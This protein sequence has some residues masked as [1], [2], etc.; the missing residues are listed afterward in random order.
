MSDDHVQLIPPE[1][2]RQFPDAAMRSFQATAQPEVVLGTDERQQALDTALFP[3]GAIAQLLI[4]NA[5]GSQQGATGTFITLRTVLTAGHA[6]FTGGAY[7]QRIQV[8]PGRNG[9]VLPFN[10]ADAVSA[11]AA[12]AWRSAQSADDDWGVAVLA[13][14][15]TPQAIQFAVLSDAELQNRPV[16]ISGYPL[17]KPLGTQWFDTK[18]IDRPLQ[19]RLEYSADTNIGQ[20]G[21]PILATI[22]GVRKIVGIHTFGDLAANSG[23]RLTSALEQAIRAISVA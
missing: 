14:P 10:W 5:D 22:G 20:S 11:F 3:C 4:T 13:Q 15:I 7:A 16:T 21:A 6:V 17:D 1:F 19:R 8:V 2:A 9:N 23:L 18:A 12:P